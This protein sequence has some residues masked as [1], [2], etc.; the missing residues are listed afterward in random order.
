MLAPIGTQLN[1]ILRPFC[2]FFR[3]STADVRQKRIW[4][5][6]ALEDREC[7][8]SLSRERHQ[9]DI[10]PRLGTVVVL[11]PFLAAIHH[12]VGEGFP[13]GPSFSR[14]RYR[15]MSDD[16][17]AINR[18]RA[19]RDDYARP[20]QLACERLVKAL[21]C[22]IELAKSQVQFVN[23]NPR[24]KSRPRIACEARFRTALLH[25]DLTYRGQGFRPTLLG[26]RKMQVRLTSKALLAVPDTRKF[27]RYQLQKR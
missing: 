23:G 10:T 14:L 9:A 16:Q 13:R 11:T 8:H 25:P 17:L 26:P 5:Q 24:R 18:D 15:Q 6:Y 19:G 4:V 22:L 21:Q 27:F 12:H 2:E 20:P 1:Q 3:V 7:T